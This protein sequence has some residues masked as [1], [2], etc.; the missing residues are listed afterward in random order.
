MKTKLKISKLSPVR[1]SL[2][3]KMAKLVCSERKVY[4]RKYSFFFSRQVL[5]WQ[6]KS[7]VNSGKIVYFEFFHIRK[8]SL[9]VFVQGPKTWLFPVAAQVK[10]AIQSRI[11]HRAVFLLLVNFCR[12]ST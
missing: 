9:G 11:C 7:P 8:N 3:T 2:F 10:P 4:R 5:P 1:K 6:S 12:I